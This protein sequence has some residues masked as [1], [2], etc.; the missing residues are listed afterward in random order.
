MKIAQALSSTPRSRSGCPSRSEGRHEPQDKPALRCSLC[1]T[2]RPPGHPGALQ[3]PL[4]LQQLTWPSGPKR[5]VWGQEH[6]LWAQ[7]GPRL[8][9]EE[10]GLS[11]HR[12]R[13]SPRP[14]TQDQ[15]DKTGVKTRACSPLVNVLDLVAVAC[16]ETTEHATRYT[17]KHMHMCAATWAELHAHVPVGPR[18]E[19]AHACACTQHAHR[20]TRVPVPHCIPNKHPQASLFK[21]MRTTKKLTERFKRG[22]R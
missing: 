16:S 19:H 13:P 4:C 6:L 12:A 3:T 18:T 22:A 1:R 17:L 15:G 5:G 21:P 14:G 10:V 2:Q 20:C 7:R 8:H 9:R 11:D